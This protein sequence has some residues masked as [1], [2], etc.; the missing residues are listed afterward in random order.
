MNKYAKL[1]LMT[2]E[3][4]VLILFSVMWYTYIHTINN[5]IDQMHTHSILQHENFT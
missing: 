3:S 5:H 4:L 2:K 1:Q